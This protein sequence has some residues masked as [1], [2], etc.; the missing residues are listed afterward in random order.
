MG[1]NAEHRA[2]KEC[3][4][5]AFGNRGSGNRGRGHGIP[6]PDQGVCSDVEI[7]H[8]HGGSLLRNLALERLFLADDD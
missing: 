3:L 8:R 4:Q 1:M 5:R 7:D 2:L 6:G